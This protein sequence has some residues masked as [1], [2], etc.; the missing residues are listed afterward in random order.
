MLRRIDVN[1]FQVDFNL[2]AK[3]NDYDDVFVEQLQEEVCYI[4]IRNI[5]KVLINI[6][7]FVSG[8]KA[9][10]GHQDLYPRD[11]VSNREE[12]FIRIV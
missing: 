2:E 5:F 10:I 1:V 8:Q 6:I 11:Y 7:Y 3:G 12:G 4:P 9:I